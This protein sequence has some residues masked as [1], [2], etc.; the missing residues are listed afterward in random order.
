MLDDIYSLESLEQQ[1]M[2][3]ATFLIAEYD[4]VPI[5]F[6][7]FA[8]DKLVYRIH[9]LYL[10]PACQKR[11]IG[12]QLINHIAALAKKAGGE[13]L[14]LNVNRKNPAVGFYEKLGFQIKAEVDIPYHHFIVNDYI[15]RMPI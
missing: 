7:S 6:A 2:N 9:K 8:C 5:G 15:M 12:A 10:L 1:M 11:G 13:A 3:G 4:K 14:E